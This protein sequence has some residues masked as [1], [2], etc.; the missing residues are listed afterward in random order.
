MLNEM[1]ERDEKDVNMEM[2]ACPQ[3]T[4]QAR[5]TKQIESS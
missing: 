3:E 5:L 4:K 1:R 2:L